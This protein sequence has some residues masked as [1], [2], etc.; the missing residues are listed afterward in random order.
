MHNKG[1]RGLEC[2][3]VHHTSHSGGQ[4][5]ILA[6]SR[7]VPAP[8]L[9]LFGPQTAVMQPHRVADFFKQRGL[10]H[11]RLHAMDGFPSNAIFA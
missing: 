6:L 1:M 7:F 3:I 4:Q 10:A 8:D 9:W 5:F 2:T 11:D